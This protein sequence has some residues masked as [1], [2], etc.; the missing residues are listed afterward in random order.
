MQEKERVPWVVSVSGIIFF[1]LEV[2]YLLYWLAS[3]IYVAIHDASSTDKYLLTHLL[4]SLHFGVS[5]VLCILMEKYEA[6]KRVKASKKRGEKITQVPEL[7]TH[8]YMLSWVFPVVVGV[9]TDT[10]LLALLAIE[11]VTSARIVVVEFVGLV[12]ALFDTA[13]I[14]V[15]SLWVYLR[16]RSILKK[17]VESD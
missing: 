3:G 8:A 11:G 9:G 2:A 17:I 12:W 14:T 13:T 4:A 15:W 5:I 10:F 6:F 7:P 16:M 1:A